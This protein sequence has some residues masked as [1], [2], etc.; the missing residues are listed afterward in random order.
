MDIYL[1]YIQMF[2][3]EYISCI[4]ELAK[5]DT[6]DSIRFSTHRLVSIVCYFSE[7]NEEILYWCHMLLGL[8]KVSTPLGDYT[9][10]VDKIVAFDRTKLGL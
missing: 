10:M 3:E 1:D 6:C 9:Y 4:A 5:K 7:T 8:P 2:R